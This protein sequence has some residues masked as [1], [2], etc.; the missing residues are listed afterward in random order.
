MRAKKRLNGTPKS[1][2]THRQTHRQTI[3]TNQLIENINPEGRCFEKIFRNSYKTYNI[4]CQVIQ[5]FQ[6][7]RFFKTSDFRKWGYL[8]KWTHTQTDTHTNI[9]TNR[10]IET[11][12][13]RADALKKYLEIV[14]K[15]I[16]SIVRLFK[17]FSYIGFSRHPTSGS[18]GT[19]K[20]EHT[21][22]QTYGQ[23]NL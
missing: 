7:Y 6:L 15:R 12:A 16:I 21:H 1:K 11:W 13:Q 4:Y 23:I 20:S 8:K 22:R 14:I 10:L 17:L 18:G 9:W 5:A 19:S 2:L 3:W